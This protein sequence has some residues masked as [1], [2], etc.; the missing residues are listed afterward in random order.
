MRTVQTVTTGHQ[1]QAVEGIIPTN[2]AK[3]LTDEASFD[4]MVTLYW[5]PFPER[6]EN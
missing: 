2:T 6:S 3:G 5:L 1:Y 4:D